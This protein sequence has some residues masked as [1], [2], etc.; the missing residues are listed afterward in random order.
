ML[1][2]SSFTE[3][4]KYLKEEDSKREEVIGKSRVILKNSKSAIYAIH[5]KDLNTAESLLAEAKK[6]IE[7]LRFITSKHPHLQQSMDNALGEYCEAACFYE[8]VKDKKIPGYKDLDVDPFTY[9]AG[10]SDLTGELGRR[11]VIEA[12]AKNN[13][14]IKEIRELVEEIHGIFVRLELRNGELRKK[15]DAIKWNLNKVEDLL[16]DMSKK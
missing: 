12:I 9:L 3:I 15:A 6:I 13:A 16:Y 14:E 7:S 8:F 4:E 2:K 5:R 1:D 11:S 10:L